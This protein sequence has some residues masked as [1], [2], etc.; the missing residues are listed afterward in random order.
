[1]LHCERGFFDTFKQ[2]MLVWTD[3]T[4]SLYTFAS[5]GYTLWEQLQITTG[6]AI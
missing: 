5:H 4:G 3:E 2:E 6:L 1:M